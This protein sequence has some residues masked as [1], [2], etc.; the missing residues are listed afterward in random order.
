MKEER[1]AA[2]SVLA[3]AVTTSLPTIWGKFRTL[4]Y[5]RPA[6][7]KQGQ[8]TECAMVLAIGDLSLPDPLV[9]IHSQCVTGE[10]FGSLRCDCR[11]QLEMALKRIQEEQRGILVYEFQEGRGIGLRR[12]LEAYALQDEG[13]DTV[14]ANESLGLGADLRDYALPVAILKQLGVR[15]LRLLSNNPDKWKSVA[16]A[17]IRVSS[18]VPCEIEPEPDSKFYLQ[19]K[20]YKM[21]H[22][23][24]L[25]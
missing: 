23:L 3:P 9:R 24:N 4:Y 7:G 20:K 10:V 16:A 21:G 11:A 1:S 12:K 14:E 18:I 19:T 6:N 17:G 22:V 8:S 13:L 15:S 2:A 5:E 25:V